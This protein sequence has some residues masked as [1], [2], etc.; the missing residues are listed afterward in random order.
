MAPNMWLLQYP[1]VWLIPVAAAG[2]YLWGRYDKRR[3][4]P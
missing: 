3:R 4:K 2:L 1:V